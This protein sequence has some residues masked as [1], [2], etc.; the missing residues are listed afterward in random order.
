MTFF[1]K[2]SL[3]PDDPIFKLPIL[4]AAETRSCKVNLGIGVYQNEKGKPTVPHCVQKA[5]QLLFEKKLDKNYLPID[6]DAEFIH[7]TLKIIFGEQSPV[8]M[9]KRVF[10]VQTVGGA[11]ALRLGAEFLYT[12]IGKRIYLSEPTWINHIN[13]FKR[14]GMEVD[15]YPYYDNAVQKFDCIAMQKAIKCMP[16]GSIIL[17]QGCGHNPTG[18]DPTF[19]EWKEL[20][21]LIKKSQ[22][23]PFFDLAYQGFGTDMDAD[24]QPIRYFAEEGH[25]MFVAYSYSKNMGLYGER[26]GALAI[27]ART[28]EASKHAASQLRQ[29]IRGIYSTPPLHGGRIVSTI[30]KNENL[31]NEWLQEVNRMRYRLHSCRLELAKRL[32]LPFLASQKGM[33]S[34]CGLSSS[35]VEHLIN[36]YAIYLPSDGRINVAGLNADNFDYVSNSILKTL[37]T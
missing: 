26:A 1:E 32:G 31:K 19:E 12:L 10:G 25:E 35:N 23:I 29:M 3:I 37:K 34:Y 6:G 9:Q 16:Q 4:F 33:F 24:A 14:S 7:E 5:E 18:A 30:L 21:H 15:F 28:P 17:L 8:L 2:I 27:V 36:E 11:G 13:I 20:S 22:L